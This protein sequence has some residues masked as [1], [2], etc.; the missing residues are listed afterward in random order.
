MYLNDKVM[1][2]LGSDQKRHPGWRT[3]PGKLHLTQ[4]L[5]TQNFAAV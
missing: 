2:P 1:A 3:F 4:P 5:S